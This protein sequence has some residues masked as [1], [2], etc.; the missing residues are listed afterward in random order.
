MN[1]LHE[2]ARVLSGWVARDA[3][4]EMF[5]STIRDLKVENERLASL[6]KLHIS[7]AIETGEQRSTPHDE[8]KIPI[9]PSWADVHGPRYLEKVDGKWALRNDGWTLRD[10]EEPEARFVDATIAEWQRDIIRRRVK[11]EVNF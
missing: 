11:H 10:L 7:S 6:C 1:E 3:I 4:D 8:L 5:V 2:K 9:P